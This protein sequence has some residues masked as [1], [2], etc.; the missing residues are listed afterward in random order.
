[1]KWTRCE[2]KGT[3]TIVIAIAIIDIVRQH[4]V[5]TV[6]VISHLTVVG[7]EYCYV[8]L[9][10]FIFIFFCF[11]L[12]CLFEN[13][14][15]VLLNHF[16]IWL[17]GISNVICNVLWFPMHYTYTLHSKSH[18]LCIY[19]SITFI[20]KKESRNLAAIWGT[21]G[22]RTLNSKHWI[23]FDTISSNN[24]TWQHSTLFYFLSLYFS[25][26]IQTH[27]QLYF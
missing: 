10:Y 4:R 16:L 13:S 15:F 7:L 14:D 6:F 9:C 19:R 2:Q 27:F 12:F 17:C 24:R 22:N 1:M 21:N 8:M 5:I 3:I 25:L 18:S 20:A 23:L 11:V 26:F